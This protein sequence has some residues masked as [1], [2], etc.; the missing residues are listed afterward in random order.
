MPIIKDVD[1]FKC[2]RC[3]YVWL[4]RQYLEDKKT[5]PIACARCKSVYWDREP[6]PITVITKRT[7]TKTKPQK[8]KN[9]KKNEKEEKER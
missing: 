1:I 6:T 8:K 4:S 7:A 5:K 3:N 9:K 2:T